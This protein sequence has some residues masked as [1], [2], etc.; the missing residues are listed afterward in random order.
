MLSS[1]RRDLKEVVESE[2]CQMQFQIREKT[3]EDMKWIIPYMKENWGSE[4]I[5]TRKT[6][7]D[8]NDIPGFIAIQNEKPAGIALYSIKNDECEMILLES[9]VE[10]TGIGS[11][12][13]ESVKKIAVTQDCKRLWLITI[14]DNMHAVRFYQLRGFSLVALYRNA[15]EESRKLKPELPMKGIDGIPLRDEIEMELLLK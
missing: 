15:I 11:T 6:V 14:N 8:T 7:D 3:N 10:K 4:K 13:I 5:V 2:L 9:F 1:R 12:L